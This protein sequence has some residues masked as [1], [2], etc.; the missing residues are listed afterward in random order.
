MK[1]THA[2]LIA[3]PLLLS[4]CAG[5]KVQRAQI[6]YSPNASVAV[7]QPV[8]TRAA[9]KAIL[10]RLG[11][12]N[13]DEASF[14]ALHSDVEA[15]IDK[16]TGLR[17][18]WFQKALVSGEKFFPMIEQVLAQKGLPTELVWLAFIESGYDF[19]IKSIAGAR[20]MWQF[21][22]NTARE[23][24]LQVSSWQDQRTDPF[25]ATQAAGE[26][27]KDRIRAFGPQAFLLVVASYNAGEGTVTRAMNRLGFS[28]DRT[29]F[30]Q[31]RNYLPSETRNY[32]PQ[33]LAAAIVGQNAA[34]YGF[35]RDGHQESAYV[36]LHEPLN[37]FGFAQWLGL[38]ADTLQ[39]LNPDLPD[40]ASEIPGDHYILR[41]PATKLNQVKNQ[42]WAGRSWLTN[43]QRPEMVARGEGI[44]DNGPATSALL[45]PVRPMTVAQLDYPVVTRKAEVTKQP[46]PVTEYRLSTNKPEPVSEPRP[47]AS[48]IT[49]TGKKATP[50]P[51]KTPKPVRVE[52]AVKAGNHLT[53]IAELFSVEIDD[54]ERWN[55]LKQKTIHPGQV[56]TVYL[57]EHLTL[58][59]YQVKKGDTLS[60]IAENLNISADA[61]CL[62]N[63][64][65]DESN[66]KRGQR[67]LYLAS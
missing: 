57:P 54:L 47:S 46:E 28:F 38:S 29:N 24:G 5:H 1:F 55:K 66:I 25:R 7:A 31:V 35:K 53:G 30:M 2:L 11:E 62:L 65:E 9:L 61:L 27:M 21:M 51:Q 13:L 12:Q 37:L 34:Y 52:Y 56:L 33:F 44:P 6:N 4:G 14:A 18:S 8:D 64:I 15:M 59:K 41:L 58:K 26:Y 48:K 43:T 49:T 20:G 50:K 45:T 16:F 60:T 67:L 10:A 22:P 36:E 3:L 42:A 23:Y 17:R 32:I 63:N 39:A 19:Q 40:F